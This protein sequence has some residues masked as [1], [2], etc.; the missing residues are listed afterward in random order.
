M[1]ANMDTRVKLENG[2]NDFMI[3]KSSPKNDPSDPSD[4]FDPFDPF[5]KLLSSFKGGKRSVPIPYMSVTIITRPSKNKYFIEVTP[6]R[7]STEKI[8]KNR[9]NEPGNVVMLTAFNLIVSFAKSF[10]EFNVLIFLVLFLLKCF[11]LLLYKRQI[12]S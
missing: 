3:A 6:A 11:L 8:R 2:I 1:A 10:K 4:P 5:D 9:N 12:F 7:E